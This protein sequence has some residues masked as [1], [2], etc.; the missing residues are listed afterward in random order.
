MW[1]EIAGPVTERL[2]GNHH[3]GYTIRLSRHRPVKCFNRL[4]T[5]PGEK[6][7]ELPVPLKERADTFGYS[8]RDHHYQPQWSILPLELLL[9][10]HTEPIEVLLEETMQRG[11]PWS[12][13]AVDRRKRLPG[14]FR[15]ATLLLSPLS[16]PCPVGY[17]SRK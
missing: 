4:S 14:T 6:S 11:T 9:I 8:E 15:H 12:A 13:G 17:G 10:D 1:I 3:A 16:G 5:A 7:Q 2:Y